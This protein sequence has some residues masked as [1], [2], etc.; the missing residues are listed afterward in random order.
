MKR[1]FLFLTALCISSFLMAQTVVV[2]NEDFELPS[3][4]DSVISSSNPAGAA[5]WAI[6]THLKNS[7]LRSDSTAVQASATTYLTTNSFSTLGYSKVSLKFA[8]ICK[9]LIQDGGFIQ[10]S[11]DGGNNWQLITAAYYKGTGVM[12]VNKFNEYS[13][14]TLW[15]GGDTLT[16]PTNNWWTTEIFDLSA[17]VANQADVKLR[18]CL[19]DGGTVGSEGRYGWLI[20]D[21]KVLA[22]N[23]EIDAPKITFKSPVYSDTVYVTGPFTI[24]AYVKDS[25]GISNVQLIY[26]E[27]NGTDITLPM[28]NVSDSTYIADIPSLAYDNLINYRIIATDIY[29]NTSS[30][31]SGGTK[32]FFIKKGAPVVQVGTTTTTGL[33]SP[34]YIASSTSTY[35]YSYSA[36]LFDKNEILSG[37]TIESLAFN[38]TDAQGY[39][40]GNATLRI[41]IKGTDQAFAPNNY[42]EYLNM[43]NNAI[44]VYENTAQNLATAAGWQT[45]NFNTG[46]LFNYSGSE[47]LLIFVEWYR[48]G[49][50]TGAVNWQINTAA[51]KSSTFYGAGSVPDL[52]NTTGQRANIKFNFQSSNLALDATLLN[53][54]TPTTPMTANINT[55]VSVRVKNLGST[56]L[57]DVDV[58]WSV[59]GVYKGIV[60]WTGNLSQD[61]VSSPLTLGNVNLTVGPHI[62]KAWTNLPNGVTDQNTDNDTITYSVF[63][64]ENLSGTFTVGTPT[65]N[66][67]TI[68]DV[69]T[70]LNNCGI[71]GAVTFKLAPGTYNQQLILPLINNVSEINTITFESASGNPD[72][73]IFEYNA[74]G[75]ADNYVMRFNGSQ[76]MIV[77]NIKFKALGTTYGRVIEFFGGASYNTL[78][79]CKIEMLPAATSSTVAGI[80]NIS[81]TFEHRN[82]IRN[83]NIQGG[84]YGIYF[85]GS[86]ATKEMGNIFEGNIINNFYYYGLYLYYQ[87]STKI[88][89]NTI[90]NPKNTTAYGMYNL[91]M[92]NANVLKNRIFMNTTTTNYCMYFSSN[93]SSA[94]NSLI[95]NNFISQ[96]TGTSTAYGIYNTSSN[97]MKYFNNSVN[98]TAGTATSYA[99]YISGTTG[100]HIKN[101]SL[102]N[103][104]GGYAYYISSTAA[105]DSSDNNNIF[106][107]G[108]NYAYWGAL[109]ANLAALQAAS[110]KDQNSISVNPQYYS[111]SDLHTDNVGLFAKGVSLDKV[112]TDIDDEPR[113][114]IP[115]IGAD[116]FIALA[117]DAKIKAIYTYGKLPLVTATPHQVKT[118]IKNMGSNT[119]TNLDITLNITGSNSFTNVK[120]IATLLPSAEDTII[121]D[122][123]TPTTLGFN[124]VK[125]SIPTDDNLNDNELNYRQEITNDAY[126]YADTALP[127]TFLGF[128]TASGLFVAKYFINDNK[129]VSKVK[130]FITGSNTIGQRIYAVVLNQNGVLVDSSSS[131]IITASD[132][133]T[134]VT[135]NMLNPSASA[136]TNNFV[137]AGIAQT[138]NS[139]SGYYP[140]GCQKETPTRRGAFYYTTNITGGSL[141]ETTQFGRFMIQAD[142]IIPSSDDARL[143]G[144]ISP[145]TN[146]GLTDEIVKIKIQ[147]AGTTPIYGDQNVITANYAVISNGNLTNIVTEQVTD[148]ILALQ[149]KEFTFATPVDMQVSTLDSNFKIIAWTDLSN[150]NIKINDSIVKVV[151]SMYTPQPPVINSPVSVAIGTSTTLNAVSNDTVNWYAN[152]TDT[153]TI[154]TGNTFTTPLIYNSTTYYVSASR[155]NVGSGGGATQFVGPANTSI[156]SGGTISATSYVTYFDVLSSSGVTIKNVDLYPATSGT[157]FVMF[158][159]NNADVIIQTYN[160]TSTT[161]GTVQTVNVNF[162]VPQGTG[163]RLGFSSGPS[164]YRNTTGAS[165][166]YTIPNVISIT[167]NSFNN[168]AYYYNAYNW[169][170]VMPGSGSVS[171]SACSSAKIPYTVNAISGVDASVAEIIT[172]KTGCN[173]MNQTVKLKIKNKGNMPIYGGLN[174]LTA[175]YGVKLAGNIINVVSQTVT[176]TILAFDSIQFTFNTPVDLPSGGSIDSNYTIIAWTQLVNDLNINNDTLSKNIVSKYIPQPPIVTTPININFGNSA[177]LTAQSSDSIYWYASINDSIPLAQ[178]SIFTTP[179]LYDTTTFYAA[180]GFNTSSAFINVGMSSPSAATSGSGTTNYGLVFDAL[181]AFNLH[182]VTVYPVSSSNA[183]GTV[184]VDVINS[185]GTVL[186]T[187]TFNVTGSPAA[188]PVPHKLILDF[189]IA[190]GTNL[191][192]RPGFTGISGLLFQPSAAAPSGGYAY[193][194]VIPGVVSINTSTTTAAPTNTPRNDLYYY[195]YDWEVG[196]TAGNA[197]GG[198]QSSK[199]AVVVNVAPGKD[200]MV[201][202][203]LS[204]STGCDLNNKE[205][206]VRIKN[207]GNMPVLSSQN[208]LT[209]YYGLKL[210]GNIIDIVS[211]TVN[212]DVMNS[213]SID[214]TFNTLLTLPAN[215]ADSNY[216]LVAWTNLINDLNINNDTTF[217]AVLSKYTPA[218]PTVS[219][220]TIPYG[221]TATFNIATTDSIYWFANLTDTIPL[222]SGNQ[223]TT[224]ALYDTTTYYVVA[225]QVSTAGVSQFVGPLN[226][227]IG[228]GGTIGA[229]SYN[230][231]FDVLSPNGITIKNVDVYPATSG[232]AFTMVIKN[233]SDVIIQTYNGTTTTTGTVQTVNVNFQVPVGIGYKL[234]FT[235][236]PSFYRNT[237]GASFPYTIPNVVSITGTSFVGYP[238]Y[239]YNAYNWE[240]FAGFGSG[241]SA[242]GCTSSKVA[243]T[244]IVTNIPAL[245]IAVTAVTE[246]VGSI[247]SGVASPVK[248]ALTNYGTTTV[249]SATINWSVNGVLQTAV[250]FTNL[251][252]SSGQTS[253]P[254]DLGNYTF[255]GGPSV[256]KAWSSLPNNQADMYPAND[257]VSSNVMGCLTG[258]FTVGT[259]GTFPSFTAAMN[260]ITSVGICGNV[261]FDVLP[262]TYSESLIINQIQ[263]MGP[264]ATITFRSQNNN[265]TSVILTSGTGSAVINL[266]GTD[267]MRFEK[268]S[269]IG[270]GTITAAVQLAGGATNNIFNGN[271]IE[272][273][274]TTTSTYRVINS[275]SAALDNYNQFIDNRITGGYYGIYWYGSSSMR[276]VG[277]IFNGNTINNFYYYGLYLYY[278]DSALVTKNSIANAANSGAVY[279]LYSY[280]TNNS[281]FTKNKLYINGSSTAYCMYLYYNNSSSGNSLVANNFVTQSNG[282]AGVYG[283]Y[284]YYSNNMNY[285]NNSINVTAGS[286]S[287]YAFYST[288]GSKNNVFNN[289]FVNT[290]GGYAYYVATPAGI[291]SSNY[292]NLYATGTNLA[293]W[294]SAQTSLA[295]LKA[296]SGKDQNSFSVNPNF[297]SN[298]NLHIINFTLDGKAKPIA[299]VTDDIDGDIRSTTTPDIGADEFVLPDNDAGV[300]SLIEPVNPVTQGVQNFKAVIKNFG[301]LN[302]NSV[303]VN[304][305][306]NG[307][308]KPAHYWT[309]NKALGETDTLIIG[310]HNFTSGVNNIK[311]WTTLPNGVNDQLSN[312]DTLYTS[313]TS[314]AGPLSGNYTIGGANPDFATINNAIQ[315]L[316]YCGINGAVTFNIRSGNYNEQIVLPS[317]NGASALNSITFKS[318]NNDSSSVIISFN[319]TTTTN[320]YVVLLDSAKYIRFK[321][322]TISNPNT[323]IGRV[324]ELK[325]SASNNEFSNNVIQAALST[326]SSSAG[327]YSYNTIDNKNLFENNV[328]TGGYYGI[329][330]YGVSTSSKEIG[331]II[332]NNVVK[333]FYYYG[334]YLYYQDSITVIGNT[335]RNS[336][337][338]GTVYGLY[339]YYADNN[340]YQ[341]NKIILNNTGT[342]YAFYMYY[343]NNASG[344]GFVAN[345]FISQ[346]NSTG[347]VYG[348][349]SSSSSNLKIYHNSISTY[350]STSYYSMYFTGG[351]NNVLR[352]NSVVNN[353]GGYAIYASSTT[354]ISSSDFNNFYTTG[355]TLGYWGGACSNLAAW[356]TTSGK[357]A[358]SKSENPDYIS[359][360]DLHVYTPALNNLGTPLAEVTEDIDGQPRNTTTPDIGADEYTPLPIDL[361]ITAILEPSVKY[362]KVGNNIDIKVIVKNFGADSVN[363]FQISYQ[364]A[365][366]APVIHN[367]SGYLLSNKVDTIT[368]T[369]QLNVIAGP[370][371]IKAYTTIANDGNLTNDTSKINYF[372]VPTKGIPYAENFDT[373]VE[374]WFQTGGTM[375]W[376]KGVPNA[377]I[378]NNAYS[379]P[380]VWATVLNGNYVNGS[381]DYLY[382]PYFNNQ[383]FKAD[384]LM[385]W[386]WMDAENNLDGGRIEYLDYQDNWTVLGTI[387]NTDTNAYNW[388]NATS[389]A[390]WT[391]NSNG[392]KQAK[393]KISNVANMG[394]TLQFR[395]VFSS[396]GS[397]NAYNGWAIDNFELTLKKIDN[398]AGVISINN[399]STCQLGDTIYPTVTVVNNGILPLSNIPIKYS[400]NGQTPVSETINSTLAPGSSMTYQFNTYFKVLS[401]PT[402]ILKVFTTVTGD[403]YTGSDTATKVVNVS[404]ATK[405]VGIVSIE[406][407]GNTV[408]SGSTITVTIKIKNYGTTP[409]TSIPVAYQRGTQPVQNATWTGP[410]LNLGDSAIFSFPTTFVVP[411]GASFTFSAYTNLSGDAYPANNKITKTIAITAI[412]ANAGSISS[413]AQFGGDTI[414]FPS[415]STNP[416]SVTYT[417]PTISNATSYVWNYSGNNV[418]YNDTTTTNSVSI[419]F[420]NNATDG[421]LT[422]YGINS[423]GN[424]GVSAPFAIDVIQNCTVGIDEENSDNFWLSQ[425]MPNPAND[426]TIIEFSI[427]QQANVIFEVVNMI[428]QS[429]YYSNENRS[430]GKHQINLNTNELSEGIYYYSI[431]CKGKRLVKK[432]LINK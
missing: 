22:S 193:P 277:N 157:A 386:Y 37:G 201:S 106:A 275:T 295:S 96:S 299:S 284:N 345:N 243:A 292:N 184:T 367:Y 252:L 62:L 103:T 167:G 181:S 300:I 356:K 53:F 72:D 177:I 154:A 156:G 322:L 365:G 319:P 31:P 258:T 94:G 93:N 43:R 276:K 254:L 195:F 161:S 84:Y 215:G 29:N 113:A 54:A 42:T 6:S 370:F 3:L 144:I 68:S 417:V 223:F 349:Y 304:W 383:I 70:A 160:G 111:V 57:T 136:T 50:A 387:G 120:T 260:A 122:A 423:L 203:I 132:T 148:T 77:K 290:G 207:I 90:S 21:I 183:S 59:D 69:F 308:A 330:L 188:T 46:S 306:I 164:F 192:M 358:N 234:G 75:T 340:N 173:L 48:P 245:D 428:G 265:N 323:S 153:V 139:T 410:A 316:I 273:P 291:D 287:A 212:T 430:A 331:N 224:P 182:S 302:L 361:G 392:W 133:N 305:T 81:S 206:K 269:I 40:L 210:S 401:Q 158:I 247:T 250:P 231:L 141:T 213:D 30:L 379:S 15:K 389:V 118:I 79:G 165:Y 110:G 45:F 315:S 143:V 11:V 226:T 14:S 24:Q 335:V 55:P 197:S 199:I 380:N 400:V 216:T 403:Y 221:N 20:D 190:P 112:T 86:S 73:V 341:K 9:L 286:T 350:G 342:T 346:Y 363:N 74:S 208:S 109:R 357:D 194:F 7:G 355:A 115:C 303:V 217:K 204:P 191:K 421:N 80:Y 179:L 268:I 411:L 60:D 51:G 58:H 85:Y 412:P 354:S 329:Y 4:A 135:F 236:G 211:Q 172:P 427:P 27:N 41:Y 285:I 283:L 228:A 34:I 280:Y 270:T 414:C 209:A 251:N 39:T 390:L 128:N 35:L 124:N 170:V 248:V 76:Y 429:V 415:G 146:C 26:N 19:T 65:S 296:A 321:H 219:N 249:T 310:T 326:T 298:T 83:N 52:S 406:S 359:N 334:M 396:N 263:N 293:Y 261:I 47:N 297:F 44:K 150:D 312:N 235:S 12:A 129:L 409:L 116:E 119:L 422:V 200:A 166:P 241:S 348:F 397:N 242:S 230:L 288:S 309:G 227:S 364:A 63:A 328:I 225:G 218:A 89:G 317:I 398:D 102:S 159:K 214:F 140:L 5:P 23:N 259:G 278:N 82:I 405:D 36:S 202:K 99:F 371:V 13:Y 174:T 294:T 373:S 351:A 255:A 105:V 97:R 163:Y 271:I 171:S 25:S 337:A 238:A 343:N 152:L 151:K 375:Q 393:Y 257:T 362:A 229:T 162:Q 95:A 360:T 87:D 117:N 347:T 262:G 327:V 324:V 180:A 196:G 91:Y 339:S 147:N 71:T 404:P 253:I 98:V 88:I 266:N 155:G 186:H 237:A 123:F 431:T 239:Y 92:D 137:Y 388:Y 187:A 332:R 338:S 382:T 178:S 407:P 384:T 385:F 374:E 394:N 279:G 264:N 289:I 232:S 256:I 56:N 381:N 121:F 130:S 425:N 413:G 395:F 372:G 100:I 8:Q 391:G 244:A 17:L 145:N 107:T 408:S 426:N 168:A 325:N 369:T 402:Y 38:K 28:T 18:F 78:E 131:R 138:Q 336:A 185:S 301:V 1:I 240:V 432:M 108:S 67:P 175:N 353:G 333:D 307:V 377:S 311:I 416:I 64:C 378:I 169:E 368:F 33:F 2:F 424:G 352:N 49:N 126:A 420:A 101:N 344:N 222:A 418:T 320:N 104:G 205:V 220:V 198:C 274:A 272:I 267:Y 10:F 114:A 314:C 281:I 189:P 176:D 66:F 376:Q 142:L 127:S 149:T 134:W 32:T 318:Q 282:T 419:E 399:S 366:L 125:I 233:S 313:I 16:K 246:P 61:F